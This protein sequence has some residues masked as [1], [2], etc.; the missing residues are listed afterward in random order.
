MRSRPVL[1]HIGGV[2]RG[3]EAGR[4]SAA[5]ERELFVG[6]LRVHGDARSLVDGDDVGEAAD[7]R[8]AFAS[9]PSPRV[10]RTRGS[11]SAFMS[12]RCVSWRTQ[13]QHVPHTG[14]ID[15]MIRSPGARGT[16]GAGPSTIPVVSC[17]SMIGPM[18]LP[19]ITAWSE[20][21]TPVAVTRTTTSRSRA[22][23]A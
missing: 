11:I 7:A 15:T 18:R 9:E 16:R 3:A 2:H 21:H 4:E 14:V 22:G 6:E 17:P 1:G 19:S 12:Q 8:D 5:D 20:W 13:C 10:A 23:P